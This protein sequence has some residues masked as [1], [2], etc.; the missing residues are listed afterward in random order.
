MAVLRAAARRPLPAA[1]VLAVFD[2][3]PVVQLAEL[4]GRWRG[5]EVPTGSR[6]DGLLGAHGWYGK[7]VLDS[8]RVQPLLF[9]D[10]RGRPHAVDPAPAP[11]RLLRRRP[12]LLRSRAA[13]AGFAAVRPLLATT[14]PHARARMV[15]S[16]GVVTAALV[17]D[18]LPVVDAFRRVSA[19]TL[20][21]LMDL[22][23]VPEPFFFLLTRE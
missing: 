15:G 4:T 16:R 6:F 5:A 19:D 7:E 8:E 17:Y 3:A 20:L 22:R 12:A 1:E 10:R 2:A 14:R 9:A 18:R 11:L 21:G 23:G 13:R